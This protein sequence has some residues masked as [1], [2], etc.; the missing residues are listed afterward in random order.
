MIKLAAAILV[1]GLNAYVYHALATSRVIPPRTPLSEFPLEL[2][3]WSCPGAEVMEEAVITNLGV[4]DYLICQ[5]RRLDS[6]ELVSL[7]VGYHETQVRQEGG[8]A[9]EN[10]IHPPKHCLPGSGWNVMQTQTARVELPGFPPG[11]AEVNRFVI[12]KGNERQLVYYWYHSRGR[13][14]ADDWQKIVYLF[15]DRARSGRTDGSLVRFTVPVERGDEAK[16]DELFR[17]LAGHILPKLGDFVP[18]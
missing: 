10:S 13:V 16:A 11:G 3:A 5:F 8:G 6:P 18:S 12:A 17:D 15:W 4:T 1:L 14:I 9:G 7:Y 2:G